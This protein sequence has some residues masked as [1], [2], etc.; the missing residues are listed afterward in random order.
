MPV[1]FGTG[2]PSR[3]SGEEANAA[4]RKAFQDL[5]VELEDDYLIDR[6]GSLYHASGYNAELKIGYVWLG[7][8][9]LGEGMTKEQGGFRKRKVYSPKK[10]LEIYVGRR[11]AEYEKDPE[12]FIKKAF[13]YR[14]S[15]G[16][17]REITER[18]K[19]I[20]KLKGKAQKAEFERIY[21]ESEIEKQNQHFAHF[22]FTP[23]YTN[24]YERISKSE[25]SLFDKLLNLRIV[26]SISHKAKKSEILRPFI[27]EQVVII[28]DL[29]N[30]KISLERI[31]ALEDL[32]AYQKSRYSRSIRN[33]AYILKILEIGSNYNW[34]KWSSHFEELDAIVN[35]AEVSLKEAQAIDVNNNKSRDFI[36][37]ISIR[38][39]RM[40]VPGNVSSPLQKEMTKL[41][42]DYRRMNGITK[43]VDDKKRAELTALRDE[44]KG[45]ISD[46]S[47]DERRE[48]RKAII[49]KYKD[50]ELMT[51]EERLAF[52]IKKSALEIEIK[53]DVERLKIEKNSKVLER[54][55]NDVKRYILWAKSQ[56]GY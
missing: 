38:D 41:W 42:E 24:L 2:L 34:N 51:S 46:E 9:N 54:L 8:N 13:G 43:E 35:E 48:K 15:D 49:K 19:S 29:T 25:L 18:Y 4:I 28:T 23:I 32:L 39:N 17:K 56:Q 14:T 7:Y 3:V 22:K 53:E 47:R 12:K 31:N 16:E 44:Y 45:N 1:S 11:F 37:P 26:S 36:A 21:L 5:D 33:E 10:E 55:E 6:N 40:I 52:D 27:E 20:E 50:L 30:I